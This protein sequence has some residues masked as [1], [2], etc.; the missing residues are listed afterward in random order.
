MR[1]FEVMLT[2]SG[3]SVKRCVIQ[4]LPKN[5]A[6]DNTKII[7]SETIEMILVNLLASFTS[8][9]P[10]LVPMRPHEA[11]HTPAGAW[12]NTKNTCR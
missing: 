12:N 5:I 11:S 10:I 9:A 8:F 4:C 3:S 7:K 6:A 2:S 1:T